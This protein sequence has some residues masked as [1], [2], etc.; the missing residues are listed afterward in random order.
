MAAMMKKNSLTY[1]TR[2]AVPSHAA[3]ARQ[4]EAM[5]YA[6]Y[7]I[8][9]DRFRLISGRPE[10]ANTTEFPFPN[11][12]MRGIVPSALNNIRFSA[13][14]AIETFRR[15]ET[16]IFTRDIAVAAAVIL[17]GG[18]AVYEAHRQPAGRL[19]LH[20]VE[21]LC[22]CRRF[23]LVAISRALADY[24]ISEFDISDSRVM[25]AH[26][27]AFPA[28]HPL[29]SLAER[30]L[31]RTR[32][33]VPSDKILLVHTGSLYKGG[34]ELFEHILRPFGE[35][36]VLIHI[37]GTSNEVTEWRKYFAARSIKNI[38]MTPH[39]PHEVARSYQAAAH[40]LVFLNTEN[41]PVYWCTSPLK[42]FE[43][44]ASGTPIIASNLGSVS[45]VLSTSNAFCFLPHD[46]DSIHSA[47]QMARR[48]PGEA[49]RRADNA[50]R[51]VEQIY[52]WDIRA[53][54]ILGFIYD[55]AGAP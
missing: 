8:L 37:G 49:Q 48:N 31:L 20:L 27:G 32:L 51:D 55:H 12:R 21:R 15:R 36:A 40:F 5:S 17:A 6:F 25:V 42:L 19:P 45:E 23:K 10:L 18:I 47:V 26:D 35:E 38:L 4:I 24:Y 30:Q 1:I 44:M 34:A 53:K 41:S 54:R 9:S 22:R 46:V 39:Q 7:N 11:L 50:R 2:V 33:D 16:P 3:Q 29:L 13:H 14:G 52:S 28:Q 43:Y